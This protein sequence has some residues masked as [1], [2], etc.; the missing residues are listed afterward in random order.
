M[1]TDRDEASQ[2]VHVSERRATDLWAVVGKVS[3]SG[4][5]SGIV[6]YWWASRD[7]SGFWYETVAK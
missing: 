4:W 3:G 6:S 7:S 1:Q 2:R 5:P